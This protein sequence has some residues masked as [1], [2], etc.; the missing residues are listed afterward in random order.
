VSVIKSCHPE[1]THRLGLELTLLRGLPIICG[2]G[3]EKEH[4]RSRLQCHSK[5]CDENTH[6]LAKAQ[7]Q[8]IPTKKLDNL[9]YC[10]YFSFKH[11]LII[12]WMLRKNQLK[13]FQGGW[14]NENSD[15]I[16]RARP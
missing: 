15:F 1:T 16:N 6:R 5:R 4:G 3:N 9:A 13:T 8:R 12:A 11:I 2:F 10:D 14:T 7:S